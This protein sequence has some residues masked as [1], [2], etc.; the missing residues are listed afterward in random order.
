MLAPVVVHDFYFANF[1]RLHFP[2]LTQTLKF[3]FRYVTDSTLNPMVGIVVTTSPICFNQHVISVQFFIMKQITI[4]HHH[5]FNR[6]RRVVFPALSYITQTRKVSPGVHA[7]SRLPL[8]I[9]RTSPRIRIRI[10]FFDQSKFHSLDK[11]APILNVFVCEG[12]RERRGRKVVC[13]RTRSLT[14]ETLRNLKDSDGGLNCQ[15]EGSELI[16]TALWQD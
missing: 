14:G 8:M 12:M 2:K 15:D 6:Y 3:R 13:W 11:E 5:T 4:N 1:L 10:S 16:T 9:Q 7:L